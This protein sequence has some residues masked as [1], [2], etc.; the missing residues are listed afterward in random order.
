MTPGRGFVLLAICLL[1]A[2]S[3]CSDGESDLNGFY[4]EIEVEVT[5][6]PAD[7]FSE[8]KQDA[9]STAIRWWHSSEPRR[10]R[11]EIET[12]GATID[13][14]TL[15]TV[16]DGQSL[17]EYDDRSRTYTRREPLDLPEGAVLSP[18][19]SAP[20]GP[21][22]AADVEA[23]MEQWR[24][25]GAGADVRRAG[26]DSVLGR[27]V[28]VIEIRPAWRFSSGSSSAGSGAAATSTPGPSAGETAGGVVRVAIDPARM[29]IMRWD[30]DGEG[31]G[32]S[33]R[34]E[35]VSLDYDAP[36]DAARFDFDPAADAKEIAATTGGCSGSSGPLG[37]ATV[38]SPPGY[39]APSYLPPGFRSTGSS[40]ETGPGCEQTAWTLE[41]QSDGGYLLLHERMRR[42][43]PDPLLAWDVIALDGRDGYRQSRGGIEQLAWQQ[44]GVAVM[45]QSDVLPVE[46]LTAVANSMQ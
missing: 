28:E 32:Q 11:W 3:A 19:F 6:P 31:G 16:F 2:L 4:A 1:F 23:F 37:G 43:L 34:A 5:S 13:A 21:A 14:G 41:M 25:R 27:R 36:I 17:W 33:Y 8:I 24:Q 10:W 22:N 26:D 20:V 12:A 15:I 46:E 42:S 38:P 7:L 44:D 30:V 9:G 35:V 39:T 40:S 29:F 45:L 18:S